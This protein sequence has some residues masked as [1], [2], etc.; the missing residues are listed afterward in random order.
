MQ[1]AYVLKNNFEQSQ[2][3]WEDIKI[4][5]ILVVN[6]DEVSFLIKVKI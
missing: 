2:V 1:I 5:D 3:F 6:K 4:G